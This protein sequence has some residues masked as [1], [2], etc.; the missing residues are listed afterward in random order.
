V[1]A[2]AYEIFCRIRVSDTGPGVPEA[3]QAKIFQR[4]YRASNARP[5]E[6]VGV[7]LYLAREIVQGQGGYLRVDSPEGGGAAF[8]LFL[9]TA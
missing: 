3:E 8:S 5:E 1:E 4:F 6:G 2:S 9:P 7:G